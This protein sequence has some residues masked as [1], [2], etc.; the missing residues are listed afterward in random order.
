[1]AMFPHAFGSNWVSC[2]QSGNRLC[3]G[4]VVQVRVHMLN[5]EKGQKQV[6]QVFDE[7]TEGLDDFGPVCLFCTQSGGAKAAKSASP[8]DACFA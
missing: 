5:L 1:M 7:W 3:G 8:A 6:S 2:I 4:P